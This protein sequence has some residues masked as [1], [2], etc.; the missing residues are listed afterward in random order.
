MENKKNIILIIFIGLLG[1]FYWYF[2]LDTLNLSQVTG[3]PNNPMASIFVN[4]I[5]FDTGLTRYDVYN[6]TSKSDYWQRRI[7]EV[8]SIQDPE[9]RNK[10]NEKLM[11]EMMEDPTL[12]KIVKKVFGFGV[13]SVLAVLKGISGR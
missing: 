13:E 10:E 4:L 9:R 7:N 12:K 2:F 6:L 11:A 3:K 5:D 8:N 1:F